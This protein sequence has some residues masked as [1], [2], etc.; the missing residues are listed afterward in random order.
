[1]AVCTAD[2]PQL[3][4]ASLP[5][6]VA[7][8]EAAGD[9][10]LLVVEQGGTASRALVEGAGGR[11]VAM[12]GRGV[13]RG[14]N[15]A[16]LAATGDLVLF[17]DDDCEVPP[18]W[19]VDHRRAV[20][21][22]GVDGSFGVVTGLPRE[23]EA[24]PVARV[25][26]LRSGAPPWDVGHSSNMAVAR[27]ALIDVGGFDERIGPGSGGVPAGE[28]A[29]LIARLLAAGYTLATGTGQPV[30]H[31]PWRTDEEQASTLLAYERGAGVWL[32]AALRAR[33]AATARHLRQRGRMIRQRDASTLRLTMSLGYGLMRGLLL[34]PWRGPLSEQLPR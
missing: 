5:S 31:A 18:T 29:D 25:R 3:L 11:Y 1:V 19:I 24:D 2:R 27:R 17:T 34:S 33:R 32:G 7:A 6:F 30:R 28:D 20:S 12:E 9:S 23:G 21:E 13:S 22:P 10:E 26:Q 14:R 4:A 8:I 15:V 16:I